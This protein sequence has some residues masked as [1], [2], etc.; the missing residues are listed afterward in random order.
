VAIYIRVQGRNGSIRRCE[1]EARHIQSVLHLLKNYS[2]EMLAD[3]C[4]SQIPT[5]VTVGGSDINLYR[6]L[7]EDLRK[8]SLQKKPKEH[9]SDKKGELSPCPKEIADV[10][11]DIIYTATL[12]ILDEALKGNVRRCGKEA[13]HIHNLPELLRNYREELLLHYYQREI[14]GYVQDTEG[15]NISVFQPLWSKLAMQIE[16]KKMNSI[17]EE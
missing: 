12:R 7:W 3:Y 6:P 10:L 11:F 8:R 9:D 15:T 4:D 14:P 1:I 2:E 17:R 13:S 16:I 5:L